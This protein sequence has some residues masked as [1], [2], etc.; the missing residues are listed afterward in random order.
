[1][2]MKRSE[3]GRFSILKRLWR[4]EYGSHTLEAALLL[5]FAAILVTGTVLLLIAALQATLTY[6]SAATAADRVAA[7]WNNSAK[8]PATG[9]YVPWQGDSLY[10]RWNEDGGSDWYLPIGSIDAETVA[11]PANPAVE[12]S[13]VRRKLA[14]ASFTWPDAYRGSSTVTSAGL[15][16][17]VQVDAAMP[18]SFSSVLPLP[19]KASGRSAESIADPAEFI[20]NVNLAIHYVP[21]IADAIGLTEAVQ[22]LTPWLGKERPVFLSDKEL[23]FRYHDDAW[24]YVLALVRGKV[25]RMDTEDVGEWRLIEALDPYGVAHQVYIDYKDVTTDDIE[26]QYLKDVELMRKGKVNGVVWHFFRRTGKEK[27]GPSE[28]LAALLRQA[29]IMIV[30]HS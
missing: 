16:K 17:S 4:N 5:P 18:L 11:L 26:L 23:S 9:M 20:R 15:L 12:T 13:V 22:N 21:K 30:I 6:V 27:Y 28:E 1:M 14:G 19:D 3:T 8:H 10:W 29:G 2:L 7:H 24:E 25:D